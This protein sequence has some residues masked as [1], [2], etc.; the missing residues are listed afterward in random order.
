M[1]KEEKHIIFKKIYNHWFT[2][3]EWRPQPF[4]SI[5]KKKVR[6]LSGTQRE[7]PSMDT[8]GLKRAIYVGI[9]R[10]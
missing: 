6:D 4:R 7:L 8:G 1:I 9:A 10:S 2:N 3:L 5:K